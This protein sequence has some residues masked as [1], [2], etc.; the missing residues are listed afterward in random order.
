MAIRYAYSTLNQLSASAGRLFAVT[1]PRY[2][3][4]GLTAVVSGAASAAAMVVSVVT[5]PLL[6][7][8]FGAA[9]FGVWM[10]LYSFVSMLGFLDFG[11]GLGLLT[12]LAH[13][14]GSGERNQARRYVSSASVVL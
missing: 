3:R 14:H 9:R 10:T 8:Q 4:A 1:D 11:V 5:T 2:R 7:H 13:C 6:L 12:A